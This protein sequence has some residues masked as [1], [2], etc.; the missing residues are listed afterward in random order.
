M[1]HNYAYI[2]NPGG[3][4]DMANN[5]ASALS[6]TTS[7]LIEV[8]PADRTKG[9]TLW[10]F[11]SEIELSLRHFSD[12]VVLL[13]PNYFALPLPWSKAKSIVV[14]HDLQFRY[15]PGFQSILKRLI[16]EFSYRLA[17]RRAAGVVFI[18]EA[19]QSDFVKFYGPPSRSAVILTPIEVA[20]ASHSSDSAS[21]YAG[22][23]YAIANFH[24]YPHKNLEKVFELFRQ[25]RSVTPKLKL[26]VT[27]RQPKQR[28]LISKAGLDPES[29][30][31]TGFIEKQEVLNL[32]AGAEFFVSMSLFEGFN[33]SAA[34]AA[35]LGRPLLLSDI[36]V[37]R[38]L[39]SE[40]AFLVDP[41]T[42]SFDVQRF[43]TY[44]SNFSS[45]ERWELAEKTEP[46]YA[47]ERYI[48]FF[49]NV[50]GAQPSSE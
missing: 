37:H 24:S 38:E 50:L 19:T 44:L 36:P 12:P 4:A 43:L 11:L 15:Y 42:T 40:Y 23:P 39:F 20:S 17:Q 22:A 34:E 30:V 41:A 8:F 9:R 16:L 49:E 32:I 33:M 46:R 29:V 26:I 13:F 18:S 7:D 45:H 31:F 5:L 2:Q 27:G 47:A 1:S 21:K 14:V 48:Q 25:L 6:Q 3:V 28:D 10:R 35:K